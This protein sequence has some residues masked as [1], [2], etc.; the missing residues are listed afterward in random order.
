MIKYQKK[1]SLPSVAL[2]AVLLIACSDNGTSAESEGT[3]DANIACP[4]DGLNAFGEPN[5]G[6]FTDERD[7]QVYKYTTIGNQVW[8]AENLKFNDSS[9]CAEESCSS[10]GRIYGMTNALKS[11]PNGW[12]LP[13]N[14]EWQELFKSVGGID[15]A[16]IRLKATAG[17]TPL[18]AGQASNG[19]DDCGFTLLPIP[20]SGI[21]TNSYGGKKND[22]YAAITWTSSLASSDDY[23]MLGILIETQ[24]IY[25][26]VT[27]YYDEWDY[28]SVR[29]VKD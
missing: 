9:P 16:G 25:A 3:F 8:M 4:V 24:N 1:I 10:K 17:W 23:S 12:H 7:G 5:R 18:N 11:C 20:V 28:L 14:D 2:F 15:S 26:K 6:T 19:T 22:G 29:C 21:Y 27:T 13:S